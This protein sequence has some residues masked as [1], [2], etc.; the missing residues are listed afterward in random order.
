MIFAV[1]LAVLVFVLLPDVSHVTVLVLLGIITLTAFLAGLS[2]L[3][4]YASRDE[5]TIEVQGVKTT[6]YGWLAVTRLSFNWRDAKTIEQH[7][8]STG[9]ELLSVRFAGNKDIPL[10][11]SQNK[12]LVTQLKSRLG[13]LK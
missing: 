7:T 6:T 9:H 13:Q 8:L 2:A 3:R 11:L 1:G 5:V 12:A 4:Q 10:A